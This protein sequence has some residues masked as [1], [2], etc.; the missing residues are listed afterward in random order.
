[1]IIHNPTPEE[2][3]AAIKNGKTVVDF[4]ANW[5]GPC[6]AQSP[7]VEQLEAEGSVNLIK[8]D[9]DE[10]DELTARF[11]ISSIPTLVLYSNGE[12]VKTFIGLTSLD[13]LKKAFGI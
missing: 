2:F 7:I 13:E 1:M 6:R 8:V 4:W 11:K 3:D 10:C 5:C 12:T 9:V